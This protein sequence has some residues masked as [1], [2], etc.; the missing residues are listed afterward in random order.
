MEK[1]NQLII[2]ILVEVHQKEKEKNI[3]KEER[4]KYSKFWLEAINQNDF[5]KEEIKELKTQENEKN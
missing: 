5:L 4:D 2:E 3:L 1:I